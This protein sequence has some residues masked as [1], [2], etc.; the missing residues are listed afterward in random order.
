MKQPASDSTACTAAAVA[1]LCADLGFALD[2]GQAA[3]LAAYLSLLAKWNRTM[4]LVGPEHWRDILETLVVDSL[5]LADFVRSLSLPKAPRC[6]DLGAGA[7]LPGVPLRML[8][9]EGEYTLVEVREKRALFLQTVL[10]ACPL[11]GVRVFRGRAEAFMAARPPAHMVV[12]R[13]FMPWEKVLDLVGGR[14]EAGGV[15]VFLTLEPLPSTLPKDWTARGEK[16]YI[17]KNT[18]RCFWALARG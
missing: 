1:A 7:G 6:W 14:L 16:R 18:A 11:P 8:W 5:F 2:G 9:R 4:N 10:A 12:S 15:C 13:A 17:V 3:S